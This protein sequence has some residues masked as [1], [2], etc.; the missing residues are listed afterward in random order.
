MKCWSLPPIA[1]RRGLDC[2]L[3]QGAMHWCDGLIAVIMRLSLWSYI[4]RPYLKSPTVV[5]RS[6]TR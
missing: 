3:L 2:Y 5:Q 1:E 4:Y 6:K